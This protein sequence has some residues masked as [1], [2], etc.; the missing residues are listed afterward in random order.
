[1]GLLRAILWD[2]DGVLVDSLEAHYL[3][4]RQA[5]STYNL[6]LSREKFLQYFGCAP[7]QVTAGVIGE[8][9]SEEV[10]AEIRRVK[11]ALFDEIAPGTLRVMPGAVEALQRYDGVYLQAVATSATRQ[12]AK[13]LLESAGISGYFQALATSSEAPGKP[14]PGVF[15]L[16]ASRLGVEVGECLVIEDSPRGIEAAQRAGMAVIAVCTT[17]PLEAL[18]SADLVLPDLT[19]LVDPD[20]IVRAY[21]PQ[22]MAISASTPPPPA[23]TARGGSR[24]GTASRGGP[25]LLH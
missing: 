11:D 6:A 23:R 10:K 24:R 5:M 4:W 17:N 2:L 19:Y 9:A 25:I 12:Q 18:S 14:D 16:A 21:A 15:L 3:S 1:L 7:A 22:A 13:L 20:T 8:A